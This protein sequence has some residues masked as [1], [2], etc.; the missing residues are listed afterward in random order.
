MNVQINGESIPGGFIVNT[1]PGAPSISASVVPD[2]PTTLSVG[3]TYSLNVTVYD[4]P[5]Q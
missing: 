1:I 3:I 4:I 5:I 2:I